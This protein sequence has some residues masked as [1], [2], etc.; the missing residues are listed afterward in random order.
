MSLSSVGLASIDDH[1]RIKD[2]TNSNTKK[3]T[4]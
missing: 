4:I 1:I 2:R 3:L